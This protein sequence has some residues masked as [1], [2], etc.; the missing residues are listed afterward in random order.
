MTRWAPIL[1]TLALALWVLGGLRQ[2]TDAPGTFATQQ[3]GRLPITS[4]GRIQPLDS[5]A[6]NSLLQLRE[7]QSANL[8]PWKEWYQHPKIIS[9]VEWLMAMMMTPE[10]AD[11][12]PVIRI[13]HPDL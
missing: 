5:L 7:K 11:T 9:G 1:I 4:N 2:P 8:E 3:F 12:W 13:D 10:V 6:R